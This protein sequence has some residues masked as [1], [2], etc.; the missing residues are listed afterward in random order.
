M[1]NDKKILAIIPARGGSKGIPHKNIMKINNKPLIAYSIEAAKESKFIDFILV[2]TDDIE[3]KN[4]SLNYGA[5][6]P[7]LRPEEIS[8]DT[9]KSIDVVLHAVEFLKSQGEEFHYVVLLQPTSP[10]RSSQDIDNAIEI[11]MKKEAES[12]VSV[13]EAS[14]NP[15][16]MRVIEDNKLK[17]FVEFKGDNLRRQDLPR[18]YIFN[19]AIYI[20]SVEMLFKEKTFVDEATIPFVMDSKKSIDIDNMLDSKLAELILRE[21]SD[22]N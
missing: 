21:K 3:I 15:V 1:Y 18:F 14:E 11:V 4:V 19:G 12:L 2:S 6:V 5:K 8:N 13:C 9:A 22:D 10:L 7:F 16:L 17:S 20:N